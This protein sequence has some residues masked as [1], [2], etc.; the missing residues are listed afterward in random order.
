MFV[1]HSKYFRDLT[2]GEKKSRLE[3]FRQK[4]AL[5]ELLTLTT[6][7]AHLHLP[8]TH[9]FS[10]LSISELPVLTLVDQTKIKHLKNNVKHSMGSV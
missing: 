1:P 9:E 2:Q 3:F 8:F 7:K 5:L 10:T 4:N 6:F